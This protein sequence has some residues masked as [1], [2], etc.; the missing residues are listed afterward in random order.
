MFTTMHTCSL[1]ILIIALFTGTFSR[2]GYFPEEKMFFTSLLIIAGTLEL[3]ASLHLGKGAALQTPVFWLLLGTACLGTSSLLWTAST[4]KTA[5]ESLLLFGYLS[6]FYVAFRHLQE[7]FEASIKTIALSAAIGGG[8]FSA[9]GLTAFMLQVPLYNNLVDGLLRAGSTFEYSNALSC[10]A[11]MMIPVSIVVYWQAEAKDR[12]WFASIISLEICAVVISF[13]RFGIVALSGISLYFLI[14]AIRKG[15]F[16]SAAIITAG[17]FLAA[18]A[19]ITSKQNH[20]VVGLAVVSLI[21]AT[22]WLEQKVSQNIRLKCPLRFKVTAV[23]IGIVA[24]ASVI[25]QLAGNNKFQKTI[26]G[27][28][29]HG[30]QLSQMLPHRLDT[31]KGAFAAFLNH[32]ITGTGLSS[33]GEV[34]TRY[35]AASYTK[36]AHNLVL[37]TAVETGIVGALVIAVFLLYVMVSAIRRL[38]NGDQLQRGF[39]ISCLIF[40]AYN[41]FD[42]EWYIPALTGWFLLSVVCI[43][44]RKRP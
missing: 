5:E 13:S 9:I 43:E 8:I 14:I 40:V 12:P 24:A 30:M 34:Y 15:G 18:A 7:D 4:T 17:G 25:S 32:P 39:A 3:I 31:F 16:V 38:A 1:Y 19:A 41:M 26:T 23:S 33:F 28:F 42:W 11:L 37:Q 21:L 35:A 44:V 2:G 27:R 10:F 36:Y 20:H 6:A 29:I 22:A